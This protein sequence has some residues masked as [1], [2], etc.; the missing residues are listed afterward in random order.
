L[1]LLGVFLPLVSVP[2]LG[3]INYIRSGHGDGILVLILIAVSAFLA[4]ARQYRALWAAG[5]ACLSVMAFTFANLQIRLAELPGKE[6]EFAREL[7]Q[8][9]WGWAVLLMGAILVVAAAVIAE[10]KGWPGKDIHIML[11]GAASVVGTLVLVGMGTWLV[12][13]GISWAETEYARQ[14]EEQRRAA[15]AEAKRVA[16]QRAAE[17]EASERVAKQAADRQAAE[18]AALKEAARKATNQSSIALTDRPGLAQEW[19]NS[20][21]F[22]V[23]QGNVRV[24]VVRL[25][26]EQSNL[27]VHL[28]VRNVGLRGVVSHRSWSGPKVGDLPELVDD[29]GASYKQAARP[30]VESQ[31]LPNEETIDVVSFDRPLDGIQWLR[32]QLPGS[33]FGGTGQLRFQI[34]DEMLATVLARSTG[35]KAVSH[36]RK[37]LGSRE[38]LVRL[39]AI[40]ALEELGSAGASAVP[41]LTEAMKDPVVDV[42]ASALKALANMGPGAISAIPQILG[43]LNDSDAGVARVADAVL[44]RMGPPDKSQI[45]AVRNALT[46]H[47]PRVRVRALKELQKMG[48]EADLAFGDVIRAIDDKDVDVRV[49]A[50]GALCTVGR[51]EAETPP[52]LKRALQDKEEAVRENAVR[53]LATLQPANGA[54]PALV[55]AL[56]DASPAVY[57]VAEQAIGSRDRFGKE[58]AKALIPLLKNK[59][60][61][62]RAF[63]ACALAKAGADGRVAVFELTKCLNDKDGEVRR[64]A[65]STLGKLGAEAC[66]A[67]RQL[68]ELLAD[69]DPSV[70]QNAVAAIKAIGPEAKLAA[71]K[72][73]AALKQKELHDEAIEALTR[74]GKNAVPALL[75]DI[76]Q[77]PFPDRVEI[78]GILRG[79]GRAAADA[80]P[81]LEELAN[82]DPYPAAR[83]AARDAVKAIQST[84]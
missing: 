27:Q 78:I 33:H 29:K 80:V 12:P 44:E 40:R 49:T 35:S 39:D 64:T 75:D 69:S 3:N 14:Q 9:Q 22:A 71:P 56:N 20:S 48:S 52:A 79:M 36:L 2:I 25:R 7:V 43:M 70:R 32:L 34:S 38:V 59:Q 42:R 4:L 65:A 66:P 55:E 41:D 16:A 30:V 8:L 1:L 68:A 21:D 74:I 77:H 28:R 50:V 67:V 10:I 60:G 63:A 57:T 13:V 58:E 53:S 82:R 37:A 73:V 81:A 5:L 31:L 45:A 83:R 51:G 72:L 17:R 54:F 6:A 84:R 15:E 76:G 46:T 23:Q 19:A 18:K 61:R 62:A 47:N 11:C 26:C 24:Q